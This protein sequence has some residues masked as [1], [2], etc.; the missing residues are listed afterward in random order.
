MTDTI[1][2][3]DTDSVEDLEA[4]FAHA[5]AVGDGCYAI[6][7]GALID[8]DETRRADAETAADVGTAVHIVAEIAAAAPDRHD[9]IIGD[10]E[11]ALFLTRYQRFV[12]PALFVELRLLD[13]ESDECVAAGLGMTDRVL[14]AV[15]ADTKVREIAAAMGAPTQ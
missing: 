3:R 4:Q 2:D 8:A 12:L 5:Q 6:D 11:S 7:I 13:I 10:A 15:A 14:D 1:T 9:L